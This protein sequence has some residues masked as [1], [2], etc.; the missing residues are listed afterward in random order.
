M[1]FVLGVDLLPDLTAE[2]TEIIEACFL[3]GLQW[4]T[5]R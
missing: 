3:K 2:Q 5:K 4:V 1:G